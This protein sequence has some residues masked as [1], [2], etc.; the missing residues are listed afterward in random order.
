MTEGGFEYN[1]E[2]LQVPK[3]EEGY[4]VGFNLEQEEEFKKFF[5]EYGLVVV[6]NVINEEE[7]GRTADEV[8][9]YLRTY[10]DGLPILKEDANTWDRWPWGGHLGILG[11]FPIMTPQACRN[12]QN[13]NIHKVFSVLFETPKLWVSVDRIG[14]MRP[15]KAVKYPNEEVIDKPEWKSVTNWLHWDMNPWTGKTST[16]A[17]QGNH[18]DQ[19]NNIGFDMLKVQGILALYDCGPNE[20][21]FHAV[22]GFQKHIRGWA[23]ANM[24]RKEA[25]CSPHVRDETTVQVPKKDPIRED[26]QTL[27]IRKGSILIWNSALPHGTFPNDSGKFRLIQYVKMASAYDA[28][29]EPYFARKGSGKE[30]NNFYVTEAQFPPG[31]QLSELGKKLYGLASWEDRFQCNLV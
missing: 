18:P 29:V 16:Y 8:W 25:N 21:G 27:P 17:F 7:C 14:M 6:K 28:A 23:Q 10:T 13:P 3:D 31:F 19:P 1:Y 5:E 11:N 15:T 22:P 2:R 20:G 4:V 9:D 24:E 26:T 12:R 30:D